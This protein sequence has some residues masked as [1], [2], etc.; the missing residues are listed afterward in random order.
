MDINAY[1]KHFASLCFCTSFSYF[2]L[3]LMNNQVKSL[4]VRKR[5]CVS[6]CAQVHMARCPIINKKSGNI[7][8]WIDAIISVFT[9]MHAHTHTTH[10]HTYACVN[11]PMHAW[12]HFLSWKQLIHG[13]PIMFFVFRVRDTVIKNFQAS[14]SNLFL[15]NLFCKLHIL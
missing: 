15:V 2:W 8:S 6:Q 12:T 4:R 5:E 14:M 3:V 9:C 7:Q 1:S 10:L 11:T 13:T